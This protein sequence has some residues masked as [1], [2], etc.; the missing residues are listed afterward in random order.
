[1]SHFRDFVGAGGDRAFLVIVNPNGETMVAR[2]DKDGK[3]TSWAIAKKDELA[4][5]ILE[6]Q[7]LDF[8]IVRF[9]SDSAFSHTRGICR[10]W[11][12][13]ADVLSGKGSKSKL[14]R[15]KGIIPFFDFTSGFLYWEDNKNPTL[16]ERAIKADEA[17][18][19]FQD[20]PLLGSNP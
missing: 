4:R 6:A 13:V 2:L 1:V 5:Q 15:M 7:G 3:P 12:E 9:L 20:S 10:Y 14:L 8:E 16:T 17:E 11:S 19:R 18:R